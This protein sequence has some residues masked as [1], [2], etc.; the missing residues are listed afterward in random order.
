M[1]S[2]RNQSQIASVVVVLIIFLFGMPLIR[3]LT[4]GPLEVDEFSLSSSS[5]KA[6]TASEIYLTIK[7]FDQKSHQIKLVFSVGPRVIIYKG[8]EQPLDQ[9]Q[10]GYTYSFTLAAE[11]PDIDKIFEVKASIE[12]GMSSATYPITLRIF[13]DGTEFTGSWDVLQLTV[14]P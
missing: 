8:A 4:R 13:V 11:D 10:Q 5:V 6:G 3:S 14:K 7:N 12:A 1:M 9:N 2:S